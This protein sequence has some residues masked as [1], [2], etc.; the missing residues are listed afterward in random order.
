M[1]MGRVRPSLAHVNDSRG[2]IERAR[3][4]RIRLETTSANLP[5]MAAVRTGEYDVMLVL[6]SP[7]DPSS[8]ERLEQIL[9]T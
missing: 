1:S 2:R 5:V 7:S 8:M 9:M 6:A 4:P 3:A